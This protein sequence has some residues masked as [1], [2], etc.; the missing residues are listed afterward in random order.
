MASAAKKQAGPQAAVGISE[1]RAL[2]AFR[3]SC[4]RLNNLYSI[5]TRDGTITKFRPRPQQR[6]IVE[7][8][9]RR[10]CPRVIRLCFGMGQQLSLVDQTLEDARQKLRDITL[11]AYESLDLALRKEL[12]IT[13]ANTGELAVRFVRHEESRTNTMFAGTHARGGANSFLW[14]SEWGVVQATDRRVWPIA[15]RSLEL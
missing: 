3:D 5:R 7:M 14:I 6:E 13:R 9:Y 12:P 8:L 1:E 15:R 2:E 4:W 10:D 11:V